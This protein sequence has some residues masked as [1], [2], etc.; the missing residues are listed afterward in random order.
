MIRRRLL[1]ASA[2]NYAGKLVTI[3]VAFALMPFLL[4][5]LGDIQYGLL[6]LIG[7]TLAYGALLDFG[8]GDAITKYVAEF[9]AGREFERAN[10]VIATALAL[11]AVLGLVALFLSIALVPV[12]TDLFTVPPSEHDTATILIL[13]LGVQLAISIPCTAFA[14]ILRGLQR[15][16]VLNAVSIAGQLLSAAAT[17]II[18]LGGG[19]V[20]DIVS[21]NL[22]LFL[23]SQAV[24]VW[25]IHR[26]APELRLSWH[27]ARRD[28]VH[29]VLAF[30]LPMFAIHASGRVQTKSDEIVVGAFLSAGVVAPYAMAR[31]LSGMPQLFA[32]QF[33]KI[34]VPLASQLQAEN[35]LHRLRQLYMVGS[36]L[37]LAI[38]I[39]IAAI[40]VAFAEPI[41]TLWVGASYAIYA[42]VVIVL[43]LAS[44]I[45]T[46]QWPGMAILQGI[47]RHH[48]LATVWV[49][50]AL[51]NVVLSVALVRLYGP[52]GVAA[53]TLIPTVTVCLGFVLPHSMRIIGVRVGDMLGAV[54]LP[55]LVPA[56]PML[57]VLYVARWV[58]DPQTLVTVLC[59]AALAGLVYIC[60][61]AAMI[62]GFER[63]FRHSFV[64]KLLHTA[65]E[66][67]PRSCE[68]GER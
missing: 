12:F 27:R 5:R 63:Q 68:A 64:A 2:S 42:P 18:L 40:I 54:F 9:S 19:S 39:P 20:I 30:S 59:T 62:G 61:Y 4:H 24:T 44:V 41:L 51:A 48:R 3:A 65:F 6:I 52:I 26:V 50:A 13:L 29:K 16:G 49:F 36:R 1:L 58:A 37:T 66:R 53:G 31:R 35:D 25:G 14:A 56:I 38:L 57:A 7:S 47:T 46:S 34:F 43:T 45:E 21:A 67:P 60:G 33:L 15:Y 17:V 8:I 32:E 28:L 23:A 22:L 10:D 55:A 11:Y